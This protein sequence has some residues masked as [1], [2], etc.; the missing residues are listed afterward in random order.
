[1]LT[2]HS[3]TSN[4]SCAI[5]TDTKDALVRLKDLDINVVAGTLKLY[6]RELP[7]PLLTDELIPSFVTAAAEEDPTTKDK[8]MAMILNQLPEPNLSTFLFLMRHLRRVTEQEKVNKMSL[9]NLATVFGPSLLRVRNEGIPMDISHEVVAQ[10][11]VVFYF[12]SDDN[13]SLLEQRERLGSV[14]MEM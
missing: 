9:H 10:V 14:S 7:E 5:D 1:G 4:Y 12:L 8:Q 6:F 11:Q 3:E 13:V 2:D